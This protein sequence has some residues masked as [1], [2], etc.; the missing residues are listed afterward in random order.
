M[1]SAL[2]IAALFFLLC[3]SWR[4]S[5]VSG[6]SPMTAV[7]MFEQWIAQYG[8]TYANESEKSYRLGVFTR[9]LDYV[10]AFRQAGNRS[11]TV[12][13]NGFADLTDEEFLATYTSTGL[14]PSDGSYPGLMPFQYANVTAPSSIDWRNEGAVTPVKNQA[15]CGSCWAFSAIASIEG[16]NKIVKGSLISLSEQQVFAC[17]HYDAGCSGGLHYRA[18]S[19]VVSSGGITTEAN[20]PYQPHQV[21]CN[22]TKQS[23]HAVSI[24]GYAMVPTNNETLLMNAVANQPVSVSVDAHTFRFYK[25]GIFDGPCGTNLDHDVTFV[26][27]GTDENGVAYWIAK[28]S[29]GAWWGDHGYIR[30]KKDVAEQEGQCGLTLR[31]SYPII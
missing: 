23:D 11:Y 29:W 1:A 18:F 31:A 7:D 30:F 10:N 9:N 8:R 19:Y 26:G 2:K 27:Y 25:G 24:T 3:G 21:A 14:S 15:Q 28:N 22:S 17:D 12:G 6:T 13:L 16:I 4:W 20:Y 5:A